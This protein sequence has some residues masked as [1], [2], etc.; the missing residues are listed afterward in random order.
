MFVY[1]VRQHCDCV[2]LYLALYFMVIV[3]KWL[4]LS[5]SNMAVERQFEVAVGKFN[6][7]DN[8]LLNVLEDCAIISS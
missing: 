7:L 5:A 4:Q 2:S 8:C 3:N 6:I 1:N